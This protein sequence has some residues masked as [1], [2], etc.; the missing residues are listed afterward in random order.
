M[1]EVIEHELNQLN[2]KVIDVVRPG[3]GTQSDAWSG[4]IYTDGVSYPLH[5]VF[6]HGGGSIRFTAEDV[7][8]VE[9]RNSPPPGILFP[10]R[11]TQAVIR[12]KGPQ[13][14]MT[15]PVHA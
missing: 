9:P 2:G 8:K 7:V 14:Y 1:S 11:A 12:L 4:I 13:Q 3:Y 10:D 5:F 15:E 6:Q